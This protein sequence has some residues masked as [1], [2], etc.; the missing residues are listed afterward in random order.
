MKFFFFI[1]GLFTSVTLAAQVDSRNFTG[2]WYTCKP[3]LSEHAFGSD[4]LM[5]HRG[6]DHC[7]RLCREWNF[8]EDGSLSI[9]QGNACSDLEFLTGAYVMPTHWRLEGFKV[10]KLSAEQI[11]RS[12]TVHQFTQDEFMLIRIYQ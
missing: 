7:M 9:G 6:K 1:L 8:F 5:F 12:Y 11:Q 2:I 4:T 3:I 10:L